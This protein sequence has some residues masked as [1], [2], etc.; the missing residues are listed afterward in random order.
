MTRFASRSRLAAPAM[1]KSTISN[2]FVR[3]AVAA[4]R[5]DPTR[6]SRVFAAAGL[7]SE[8]LEASHARVPA[9]NFSG[10]W[11]AVAQEL[12]DEFLGADSRRMKVGTFAV[13][14]RSL[15]HAGRLERALAQCLRGLGTVFDDVGAELIVDAG[16]ARLRVHNRVLDPARR[17]FATELFLII[18]H[19]VMCWL[20][21]RRIP[22]TRAAFDFPAPEHGIEYHVMF[23]SELGFDAAQTEVCFDPRY[24][25]CPLVQDEAGLKRFL[26][27]APQSVFIKYRNTDGWAAR[28][29]RRLRKT[30]GEDW[31]TFEALAE[32]LHVTPSTLRRR[33]EGEGLSYRELKDGLRRDKAI[34][35]LCRTTLSV[36]AIASDLGYH[37]VS[38][39]YRAFRHWTGTRPGAYRDDALGQGSRAA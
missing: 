16:E 22:L 24:L 18:V 29:R 32:E 17:V 11:L 9:E 13:L 38:A 23:C 14:C 15:I 30:S 3:S 35:L 6:I 5:G 25:D 20:A 39:F 31:P 2:A 12:D 1:D 28:V 33:L 34:D 36:E 7:S 4:L 37:E 27:D 21:G 26:R 19:G 8:L 10:L